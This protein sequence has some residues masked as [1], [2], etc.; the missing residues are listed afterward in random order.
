MEIDLTSEKFYPLGMGLLSCGVCAPKDITKEEVEKWVNWENPSGT[1]HGWMIE[2]DSDN[3]TQC[4]D[5]E[6]RW[7][8]ILIC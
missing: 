6:S 1:E 4:P 7:H 3:P 5:E 2:E 8:W